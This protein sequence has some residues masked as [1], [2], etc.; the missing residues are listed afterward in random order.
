MGELLANRDGDFDNDRV[1]RIIEKMEAMN[2]LEGDLSFPQSKERTIGSTALSSP[3][4]P[5]QIW[6]TF[7]IPPTFKQIGFN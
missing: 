3:P 2:L 6:S 1:D 7:K 4:R 5:S